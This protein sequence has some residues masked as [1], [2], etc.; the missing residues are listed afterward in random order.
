[1]PIDKNAVLG[2]EF[3]PTSFEWTE[4]DVILYALGLGV[5]VG[6]PPTDPSVLQYT[7]ENGLKA[8][9]T[10]GVV[11]TFA[12]LAGAIGIPGFD[13]NPMMILH[14]EQYL[15]VL[16]KEVPTRAKV[17]NTARITQV[18]DKGKGALVIIEA[19]T[20]SEAGEPIFRNDYSV[21]IRGEGGFGGESGPPPGNEPPAR[22][23]DASVEYQTLPH[24]AIIYRLSGDYN[25]LHIDPQM[26]AIAGFDRPILHGLCTFGNV[27]RAVIQE[28]CDNDPRRF[29]SIKARFASPVFPG[30]AIVTDMWK[31]S[32]TDVIVSARVPQRGVDVVKNARVV[33]SA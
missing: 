16:A 7:Y 32:A 2:K 28:M 5:G 12:C 30:E 18:Y 1:M 33:I 11:P 25:P 22:N 14:G 17:T 15:E 3:E 20:K 4:K 26:A 8:I 6:A 24:Q 23:P 29:R 31:A 9:P 13:V 27:A 19:I 10:F 21:F